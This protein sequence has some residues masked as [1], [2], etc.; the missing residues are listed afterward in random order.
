M[1]HCQKV[2]PIHTA[3]YGNNDAHVVSFGAVGN[4]D[5]CHDNAD[6]VQDEYDDDDDDED[7]RVGCAESNHL[8]SYAL[9][10]HSPLLYGSV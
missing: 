3:I 4:D 8:L 1:T 7:G 6:A 5:V 10:W 2:L 9:I